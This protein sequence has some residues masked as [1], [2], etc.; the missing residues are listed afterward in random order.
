MITIVCLYNTTQTCDE[1]FSELWFVVYDTKHNK[2]E[3][4]G[5]QFL[6]QACCHTAGRKICVTLQRSKRNNTHKVLILC[7]AHAISELNR[8][9]RH[10]FHRKEENT[11]NLQTLP[12]LPAA[13]PSSLFPGFKKKRKENKKMLT[14][15]Y[16]LQHISH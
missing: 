5:T 4:L 7:S 16:S 15:R 9:N 13:N 8:F 12:V 10:I 2:Y 11:H 14:N 3:V 6:K 1:S